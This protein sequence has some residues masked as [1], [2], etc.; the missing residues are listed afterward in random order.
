MLSTSELKPGAIIEYEGAPYV[1]E[2]L[3][4]SAP[5]ARGGNTI[6]RV[7]LRN[8]RTKMKRDCSFRGSETFQ[9]P[10]YERRSCQLLYSD[11]DAYH[12]MDQQ[13]FEQFSLQR[14][15][16]EWE[17]K[18][19]RDEIEGLFALR[20]DDEL[21]GLELPSTVTLQ[22]TD[23]S[24]GI[25]GASATSRNKPATLETGHVIKVPEHI[26][27]GETVKV[28]TRTGEFLGRA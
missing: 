24:P 21:L 6:T 17:G 13:N 7:R 20:C 5:T 14:S 19:L 3:T 25:K 23:T 9:E 15:D 12:F 27:S 2:T 4:V 11:T 18:F 26:E 10:A 16:L 1:V 22:I 8:L 28:D